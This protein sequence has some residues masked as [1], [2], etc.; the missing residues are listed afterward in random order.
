MARGRKEGERTEDEKPD[1]RQAQ[2]FNPERAQQALGFRT[3]VDKVPAPHRQLVRLGKRWG[4]GANIG[5]RRSRPR[6]DAAR[7]SMLAP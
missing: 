1:D 6:R 2:Q 5:V 7:S 4:E 3:V